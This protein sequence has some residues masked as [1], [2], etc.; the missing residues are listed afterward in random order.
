MGKAVACGGKLLLAFRAVGNRAGY[1]QSGRRLLLAKRPS[2]AF[3]LVIPVEREDS[4]RVH[5]CPGTAAPLRQAEGPTGA[6][7]GSR[8]YAF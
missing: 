3:Q 2:I 5:S 1:G 8:G 4:P 7:C 6:A